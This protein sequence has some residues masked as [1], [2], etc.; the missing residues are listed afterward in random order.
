MVLLERSSL[1]LPA[2]PVFSRREAQ[3]R[4]AAYKRPHNNGERCHLRHLSSSRIHSA[5]DAQPRTVA[6]YTELG[7]ITRKP[8]GTHRSQAV[9]WDLSGSLRRGTE[10]PIG[11]N[12][13]PKENGSSR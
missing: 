1:L 8:R 6:R 13:T 2:P 12:F 5:R 3:G 9:H 4:R 10:R 11:G 7:R